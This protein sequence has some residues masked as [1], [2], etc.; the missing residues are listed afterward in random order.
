[1]F[2]VATTR[3]R[4]SCVNNTELQNPAAF[5]KVN[6]KYQL[7]TQHQITVGKELVFLSYFFSSTWLLDY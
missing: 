3:R 5:D 6:E 7:K 1:M 2:T 4:P